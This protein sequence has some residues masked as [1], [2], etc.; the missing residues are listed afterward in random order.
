MAS[1]LIRD[2]SIKGRSGS[3]KKE[4][5][6]KD[7]KLPLQVKGGKGECVWTVGGMHGETIAGGPLTEFRRGY[8]E[9]RGNGYIPP[10][11]LDLPRQR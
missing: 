10:Q 3:I 4:T 8:L 5:E 1:R 6:N 7:W 11:P 2:H 9:S